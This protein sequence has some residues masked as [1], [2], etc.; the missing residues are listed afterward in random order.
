MPPVLEGKGAYSTAPVASCWVDCADY[1]SRCHELG[2]STEL[3][4]AWS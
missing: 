2:L 4:A 3:C 1:P